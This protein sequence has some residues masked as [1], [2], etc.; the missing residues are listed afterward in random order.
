MEDCRNDP[1]QVRVEHHPPF[2]DLVL[3][4]DR[5][6]EYVFVPVLKGSGRDM[7]TLRICVRPR[8]GIDLQS[9]S[10]K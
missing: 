4:I 9:D 6:R 3:K 2:H 10:L 5:G 8:F 1:R 7:A